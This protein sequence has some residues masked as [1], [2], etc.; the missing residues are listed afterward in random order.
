MNKYN[1]I[2]FTH[3]FTVGDGALKLFED[4]VDG[5][6]DG[7]P[8][9]RLIQDLFCPLVEVEHDVDVAAIVGNNIVNVLESVPGVTVVF[10]PQQAPDILKIGQ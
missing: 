6:G 1:F 8:L 2:L 10:H 5:E 7:L 3:L 4:L 9:L